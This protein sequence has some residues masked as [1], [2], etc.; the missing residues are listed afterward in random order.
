MKSHSPLHIHSSTLE[1]QGRTIRW[2]HSYDMVVNLLTLGGN[3]TLREMT[4]E[5]A[6][7]KPGE[8]VL[9]VGCGTGDL[10]ML[11]KARAGAAGEVYGI[12][13][14]PEMIEVAR[15]KSEQAGVKVDFRAGLIESLSFPDR[16]FDA[17]LSSLMMHH[18]PADLKRRGLAEIHRVLKPGGRLLVVD[19]K[20]PTTFWAHVLTALLLHGGLHRGVQ[21]LQG[22]MEE[23]GFVDVVTGST[24][25]SVLGFVS[26][27]TPT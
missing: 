12:D 11:A 20:R 19:L 10:T 13:A 1:T 22:M 16:S 2:A 5:L 7:I 6:R 8:K 21:D 23:V 26:G 4:I 3:K 9:D 17:V 14:S 27:R 18:L 24:R 25:F 15:R